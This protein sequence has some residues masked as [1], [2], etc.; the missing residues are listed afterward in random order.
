MA[1]LAST[2]MKM[3]A[4]ELMIGTNREWYKRNRKRNRK[5]NEEESRRTLE[6]KLLTK[7]E[8][9]SFSAEL[10]QVDN[11]RNH[12]RG[13]GLINKIDLVIA[14]PLLSYTVISSLYVPSITI[15]KLPA[16]YVNDEKLEVLKKHEGKINKLLSKYVALCG[17]KWSCFLPHDI[18]EDDS[19]SEKDLK[20]CN[21]DEEEDKH[22][23]K[24]QLEEGEHVG[25][26][27][28]EEDEHLG[29]VLFVVVALNIKWRKYS[30][31]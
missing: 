18:L 24:A 22:P 26:V 29:K 16:R 12:V 5:K 3:R 13:Y 20:L 31:T 9:V 30:L 15:G 8:P 17:K 23:G 7:D 19:S 11:L 14:S 6:E 4:H 27:Q 21:V 10:S 1:D 25:K 2:R 28:P